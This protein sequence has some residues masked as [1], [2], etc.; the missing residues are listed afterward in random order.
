MG[1]LTSHAAV[2][3]RSMGKSAVTGA[4]DL[5]VDV[6]NQQLKSKDGSI[7]LK[8]GDVI[9]IDGSTGNVYKGEIPTVTSGHS[10]D[11][12]AILLWADK[13]K[14]MHVLANADTP[15]EAIKALELGADGI[16]LCRTEHMFFQPDRLSIFRHLLLTDSHKD[17]DDCLDKLSAIQ[18]EDFEKLFSVMNG[19]QVTIRLIDPPIHEFMPDPMSSEFST[20]VEKIAK[21]TGIHFEY[22]KQRILELQEKNPM[23]GCRGC[24]L[25]IMHPEIICMQVK[26]IVGKYCLL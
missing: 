25:G 4:R 22:C 9:T 14:D 8:K 21:S 17:R 11:F 15:E 2:V 13:Y 18:Q 1:G 23:M 12:Q 6:Q 16:G 5:L 20:E 19:R 10:T 7:V 3:M 24:R 26:A